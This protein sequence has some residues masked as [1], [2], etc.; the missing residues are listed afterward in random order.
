MPFPMHQFARG[1]IVALVFLASAASG[2]AQPLIFFGDKDLR[3]Y[4]FLENGRPSGANVDLAMAL[5]RE[6]GRPTEVRLMDW[7]EAQERLLA[8]EGHALT[9]LART[10]EREKQYAFTQ[11]TTP[12]AF[13]LFVRGED[14]H[15]FTGQSLA[16]K[17]IGVTQGGL[18]RSHLQAA[19]PEAKY[20]IVDTVLDGIRLIGY[21]LDRESARAG[22]RVK[23][24]L[25]WER[26]GAGPS[27]GSA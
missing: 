10:P 24:T 9:M 6:L 17:T 14:N 23:L 22:E 7:D 12:V 1:V 18:A 5:G 13:A 21:D 8:G 27:T 16:G 3:P 26:A 20:V 19:H 11:P 15:R 25:Y 4:E 2:A